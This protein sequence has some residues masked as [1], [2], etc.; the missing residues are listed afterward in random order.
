MRKHILI[1][2]GNDSSAVKAANLDAEVTLFQLRRLVTQNQLAAAARV[3][4]FDIERHDEALRLARAVHAS[5]PLHAVASFWERALL[6]ASVIGEELGIRANPSAAVRLTRDKLAM[7]RLLANNG[8]PHVEFCECASAAQVTRFLA[9][10]GGPIVLKPAH[11]SGS[12]GVSMISTRAQVAGA[13]GWATSTGLSPLLAEA[14]VDGP[15]YSVESLTLG[16]RH[17][18]LGIT[19]KFTTGPPHFIETGHRFPAELPAPVAERIRRAVEG[20]LLSVGHEVGPAHTEIRMADGSP[21]VIETQTRFGGD[22]I[23]EMVELVSGVDLTRATCSHLLGLKP[24]PVE[25]RFGGAAIRFFAYENCEVDSVAGVEEARALRGVLRVEC[26]LAPGVRLGPLSASKAR[27]GYVLVAADS[28][29]R[30]WEIATEAMGRVRVNF[31]RGGGRGS[32]ALAGRTG[33][34]PARRVRS[35]LNEVRRDERSFAEMLPLTANENLPSRASQLLLASPLGNRYHLSA[36]FERL[37]ANFLLKGGLMIK[38]LPHVDAMEQAA[39]EAARGMFAAEFSDLRPLS[40]VHTT[41]CTL[42]LCTR[43]G[44]TVYSISPT[45]GGHFA[46]RAILER[47]G[48]RSRYLPWDAANMS[49]DLGAL[50]RTFRSEP[51]DAILIDLGAVIRPLPTLAIRAA[52]GPRV[53]ILYDASHSFG[54][55]AGGVFPNPLEQGCDVLQGNTHKTFPGP[56]KGMLHFRRWGFG[57]KVC[58]A[59]SDGFVSTQHTHHALALY[60]TMLEM[61][62]YGKEYARQVVANAAA[63]ASELEKRGFELVRA[64]AEPTQTN[65]ILIN[66]TDSV[67]VFQACDTLLCSAVSTNARTLNGRGVLRLGT[68]EATRRGMREPEMVWVA[69]LFHRA[70]IKREPP[71]RLRGEVAS[72]VA[73]FND[74]HYSFDQ[75]LGL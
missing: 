36:P 41:L 52:A 73:R 31:K 4:L 19:E 61:Q 3:L 70:L 60:L 37:P 21:V 53:R 26:K 58:G 57:A 43:P 66:R 5:Q 63:L 62:T 38:G 14:Y 10:V 2:G 44:D 71:A 67:D 32:R 64:G 56:Q 30:A 39:H 20:L 55:I 18:I 59:L 35:L 47:L 46:T 40:G 16:G 34:A 11:G 13:W 22:Q 9:E 15:E 45:N 48:R 6:P 12:A 65:V 72:T 25:P 75:A 29:A 42:S 68:Q 24:Y 1:V 49:C 54:L 27:Q 8:G 51:P 17:R 23:W 74:V 33:G 50:A 69:D 7:R 28:A